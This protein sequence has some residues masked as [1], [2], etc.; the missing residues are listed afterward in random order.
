MPELWF[1]FVVLA[2][3]AYAVL[4]G[5]D[6]FVE[7]QGAGE[8]AIVELVESGRDFV[9]VVHRVGDRWRIDLVDTQRIASMQGRL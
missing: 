2:L 6:Y 4:D 5:F 1:G 9:L 7:Q 8:R 3:T